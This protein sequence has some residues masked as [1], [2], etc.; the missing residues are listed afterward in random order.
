M[1]SKILILRC[2]SLTLSAFIAVKWAI[3]QH[4]IL[5]QAEEDRRTIEG[6]VQERD[7]YFSKLRDIEDLCRGMGDN[8]FAK[9]FLD[10]LYA[11]EVSVLS[12]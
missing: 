8:A 12:H 1:K 3:Q 10:I 5:L 6:L 2:V 9:K 4:F 11:T 7:F